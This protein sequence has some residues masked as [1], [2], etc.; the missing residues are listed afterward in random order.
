MKYLLFVMQYM[1]Q[2]LVLL[3][4]NKNFENLSGSVITCTCDVSYFNRFA[5]DLIDSFLRYIKNFDYLHLHVIKNSDSILK[6][7]KN[8]KIVI[9]YEIVSSVPEINYNEFITIFC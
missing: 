8:K 2:I 7:I 6:C 3:F 4:L 9:S 5:D 1:I